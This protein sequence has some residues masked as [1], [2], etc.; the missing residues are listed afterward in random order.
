MGNAKFK[1][2]RDKRDG[3]RFVLLPLVVHFTNSQIRAPHRLI[4]VLQLLASTRTQRNLARFSISRP[5]HPLL[6]PSNEMSSMRM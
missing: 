2:N 1:G 6:T 5:A 3:K 4:P